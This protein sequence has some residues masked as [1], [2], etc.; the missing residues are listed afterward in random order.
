LGCQRV[1][2]PVLWESFCRKTPQ[3]IIFEMTSSMTA[4]G[5]Q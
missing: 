1:N 3:P 5:L 4:Q 2:G